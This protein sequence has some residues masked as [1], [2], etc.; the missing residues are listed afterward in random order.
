MTKSTKGNTMTKIALLLAGIL[1]GVILGQGSIAHAS[2]PRPH[3]RPTWFEKVPCKSEDS[4]NCFWNANSRGNHRG[5]S[6][7]V[8]EM[9]GSKHMVCVMYLKKAD[10]RWDYCS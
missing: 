2:T 4:V 9:P 8:R 10:R 1:M 5:H 6:F 3:S 7:I